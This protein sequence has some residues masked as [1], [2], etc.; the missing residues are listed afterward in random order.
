MFPSLFSGKG[1]GGGGGGEGLLQFY[2]EIR[3]SPFYSTFGSGI[4]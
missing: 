1:G 4:N 2:S 3:A